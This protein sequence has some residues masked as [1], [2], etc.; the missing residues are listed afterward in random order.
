M[1]CLE[2]QGDLQVPRFSL[3]MQDLPPGPV[4][5]SP[6]VSVACTHKTVPLRTVIKVPYAS[7]HT[8]SIAF[9]RLIAAA[10]RA[11]LHW[12]Q[13]ILDVITQHGRKL[14]SL[15][16]CK[17]LRADT[18]WTQMLHLLSMKPKSSQTLSGCWLGGPTRCCMVSSGGG[19]DI[20]PSSVPPISCNFYFSPPFPPS[21][22][23]SSR[24]L[25]SSNH[26]NKHHH[27]HHLVHGVT[28]ST[29]AVLPFRFLVQSPIFII[30]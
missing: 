19:D 17:T 23:I 11:Q 4:S 1:L 8:S 18:L 30:T 5:K 2:T 24:A 21:F 27:H 26:R 9:A 10:Q 15:L 16:N 3:L 28:M 22:P 6:S 20:L 14:S 29:P 12:R 13:R 7:V 25:V